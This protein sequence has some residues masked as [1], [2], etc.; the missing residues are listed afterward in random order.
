MESPCVST[1]LV[2]VADQTSSV[3]IV[4]ISPAAPNSTQSSRGTVTRLRLTE[5]RP[6]GR[7][8]TSCS[9]RRGRQ[10]RPV[11]GERGQSL[12]RRGARDRRLGG[13][14]VLTLDAVEVL[15]DLAYGGTGGARTGAALGDH[16]DDDVVLGVG[17][18]PR[19]A[20]LAVDLGRAGL[21]ADRDLVQGEA[22]ELP[23][24]RSLLRRSL[25][26]VVHVGQ[27]GLLRAFTRR[28]TLGLIFLISLPSGLTTAL[29]TWGAISLPP[30]DR[31]P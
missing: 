19:G 21:A 26:G 4:R 31:A 28:T 13:P 16:H 23:G 5:S 15:P 1:S 12:R 24:Q 2:E 25:Q 18:D 11:L 20:L 8:V 14:H 30:L 3:P 22:A 6:I 10:D 9:L 7:T 27:R 17:G 29:A